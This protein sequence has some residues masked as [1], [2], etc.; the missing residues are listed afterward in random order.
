[1][2]ST[3]TAVRD[4]V[5]FRWHRHVDETMYV[6]QQTLKPNDFKAD[7]PQVRIRKNLQG[8][9]L[10]NQ[11]PDIFVC[12]QKEIT[13]AGDPTFDGQKFADATF[14]G[15]N[16][17]KPLSSFGFGSGELHTMMKKEKIKL[18][19]G[20]TGE[21]PYLDHEE[22]YY[23]LRLENLLDQSQKVTVRVFLVAS[24]YAEERRQ[25]IEMDKFAQS[26]D[27]KQKAV[28]FRP[29]RFSSVVRKPARRPTDPPPKLHTA[30]DPNYCDCGWP[31]HLLLPRGNEA[32]MDFHLVVMLTDFEADLVGAEKKCG[33]M[34]FCG[35]KDADYPDRKPMGYPFDRPFNAKISE[36]FSRPELVNIATRD[37][38]IRHVK[39]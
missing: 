14:G 33:S 1:M 20:G 23:F 21:K 35:V 26:L 19:D 16:W 27:S 12:M 37:L 39:A 7:A 8:T 31:Y 36:V 11:S 4:P 24:A 30:D 15:V 6:W 2:R 22:F 10:A 13:G 29:A 28:V 18:P 17:D 5:F 25:W 3:A 38:K 34:S 9:T 32:G